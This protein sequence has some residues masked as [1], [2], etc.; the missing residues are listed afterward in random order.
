MPGNG[1]GNYG[2]GVFAVKDIRESPAYLMAGSSNCS[3]QAHND[4]Q[5][6]PLMSAARVAALVKLALLGAGRPTPT[7]SFRTLNDA[8]THRHGERVAAIVKLAPVAGWV[9]ICVEVQKHAFDLSLSIAAEAFQHARARHDGIFAKEAEP[10]YGGL[11][12]LKRGYSLKA[13][14]HSPRRGGPAG[15][16]AAAGPGLAQSV[17]CQN[18]SRSVVKDCDATRNWVVRRAKSLP[19]WR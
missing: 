15:C 8:A 12:S 1:C 5:S 10:A 6:R 19:D 7:S 4:E 13:P 2:P 11:S 14:R 3:F 16:A 9:S 18:S 17:T